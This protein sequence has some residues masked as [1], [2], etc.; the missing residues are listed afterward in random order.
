MAAFTYIS[1]AGNIKPLYVGILFF[2][3]PA[4][5]LLTVMRSHSVEYLNGIFE[6]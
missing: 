4:Y 6:M 5:L 2:M 1:M 3:V